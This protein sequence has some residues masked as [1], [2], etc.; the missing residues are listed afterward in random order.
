M[1][2]LAQRLRPAGPASTVAAT[3][4]AFSFLILLKCSECSCYQNNLRRSLTFPQLAPTCPLPELGLS[5]NRPRTTCLSAVPSPSSLCLQPLNNL[6]G[7]CCSPESIAPAG[8]ADKAA[9]AEYFSTQM[10]F[11]SLLP[12]PRNFQRTRAKVLGKTTFLLRERG[13]GG[14]VYDGMEW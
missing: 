5:P 2:P 10:A 4:A 7:H 12:L 14:A 1:V 13:R 3:S 8:P 9:C 6:P 11:P